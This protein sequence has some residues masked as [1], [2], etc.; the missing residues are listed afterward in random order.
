MWQTDRNYQKIVHQF[1]QELITKD[2]QI[3]YQILNYADIFY[4]KPK[5]ESSTFNIEPVL[6]MVKVLTR[7]GLKFNHLN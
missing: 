4:D 1:S 3:F 5:D 7:L 6:S 2:L